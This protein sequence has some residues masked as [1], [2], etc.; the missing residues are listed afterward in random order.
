MPWAEGS[1]YADMPVVRGIVRASASQNYRF[2]SLVLGIVNSSAFR[3]RTA[4][5]REIQANEPRSLKTFE[6]ARSRQE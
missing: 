4:A 6:L 3:M 5:P 1:G 2:S